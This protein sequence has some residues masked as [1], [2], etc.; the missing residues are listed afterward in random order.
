MQNTRRLIVWTIVVAL[1]LLILLA[2]QFTKDVQWNETVAYS[3]ILL[4]AGGAYELWQWLKTRSSSYRF[5]FVI[6][7]A[8]VL[9]LGWVNGAV[10]IIGREN[11]PANLMY[12]AVFA[13]GLAGSLLSR[14][15]PRG[16]ARALFAVAVVQMLVPVFALF[17]WPAQASW[18]E[19]GVIGVFVL[20]SIFAVPFVLSSLLFRRVSAY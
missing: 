3:I 18:G 9:L 15:R 12:W 11:N 14:F 7:L 17:I 8:G 6:G 2:M 20:N 16:M 1:I 4:V 10:G 19:A 5:A 13:V